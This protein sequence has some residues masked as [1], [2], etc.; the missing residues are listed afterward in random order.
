MNYIVYKTTNKINGKI[1]VGVHRTNPDIFD[2][3]IGCGVTH[4]DSKNKVIKGFPKA[5][6]KYGYKNFIRETLFIFPDTEEGKLMAYKKEEEIVNEEFIKRKDT[7]NLIKGGIIN[8]SESLKKEIA[9]YTIKGKFIR[10][11]SSIKEA[12]E[13]L[14]IPNISQNLIGKSKYSGNFQWKYYTG[15]ES[16]IPSVQTKEKTVYQFDLQG[17]LV[18]VWKSASLA[19]QQFE[20]YNSA[21]VAI[22]NNCNGKVNKAYGYY[23]S[24]KHI[25]EYKETIGKAVAKYNDDGEFLEVY[26]SLAE[27]ARL[28]NI[29]SVSGIHQ[30]IAGKQKRCGGFRWRYFYG[31]K[32][33][34]SPLKDKD[35]V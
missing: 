10:T 5:V 2:G 23:W 30:A 31:N 6:Q 3:Y 12:S 27:A 9:Q 15:D 18:K 16:D 33:N 35:I 29:G 17:N 7:Y 22:N 21:R 28:N 26:N 11:W 34:I 13:A 32:S 20:N 19:A 24:Y 4:K 1:Y 25:F 14:N 8:M